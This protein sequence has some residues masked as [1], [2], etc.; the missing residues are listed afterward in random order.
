MSMQ[1]A[2]DELPTV[3][4][5]YGPSA[6]VLVGAPDGPPRVTHSTVSW[7]DGEIEVAVGRRAAAALAA[8]PTACVLWPATVDQS[9]SLIVDVACAGAVDDDGGPVRLRPTGAVRH[10]PA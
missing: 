8:N 3:S 7:I 6:Y 5:E 9:M 10:R 1:V 2:I 4:A